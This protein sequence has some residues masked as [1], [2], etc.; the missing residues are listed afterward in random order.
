MRY[1]CKDC[2]YATDD[3]SN[4]NKHLN[5]SSHN[6]KI[7]YVQKVDT[8]VDKKCQLKLPSRFRCPNCENTYSS[9][10]SL[11]RHKNKFCKIGVI[12]TKVKTELEHEFNKKLEQ[13]EVEIELKYSKQMIENMKNEKQQLQ[14]D[15]KELK[16]YIKTVKP[17]INYNISVKK[18]V[19]QNYPDAPHLA[20]LKNYAVIHEDEDIDFTQDL[21]Y[22]H[23]KNKLNSYLGDI[24]IKFYKKEDPKDQSLWSTDSS[25]LK[26]IIKELIASKKSSWSED[27]KGLKINKY[28]IEPL[29]KYI[30]EYINEQIDKF[31]EALPNASATECIRIAQKQ[32]DLAYIRE[33]IQN[34]QLKDAVNRYI[35]PSFRY[36]SDKLIPIS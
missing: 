19:Q 15:N 9:A 2:N 22:Y 23:N 18:L 4:F 7:M 26:Y 6:H 1:N 32:L 36:N 8:K 20:M 10:S 5:S 17:T 29:L 35:A 31:D 14:Q 24:I 27:D 33:E 3:K 13:K 34:G 25:R 16:Q 11:S 28:I 30:H 12:T 21:I